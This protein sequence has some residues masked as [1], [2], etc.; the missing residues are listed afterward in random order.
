MITDFFKYTLNNIGK[1]RMRSWLTMLG[2]F[3]GIASVVALIGLGSGLEEAVL[4][5][6][7]GLG[8]DKI[9]V[10]ASGGFGPPGSSRAAELSYDDYDVVKKVN[11][12]DVVTTRLLKSVSFEWDNIAKFPFMA[13]IPMDVDARK[14]VL[15]VFDFKM[16]DGR[17][18]QSDDRGKVNIG[19]DLAY[20]AQYNKPIKAGDSVLINNKRYEVV[21]VFQETGR[22]GQGSV[23]IM[24]DDEMRDLLDVGDFISLIVGKVQNI[25]DIDRMQDTITRRLRKS[26]DVKEGDEDFDVQTAQQILDSFGTIFGTVQAVVVGIAGISL[27][28]GAIGIMNTMYTAVLERRK[29]IGIMKAIG[30]RNS[31]ILVIFILESGFLGLVG[32][33]VGIIFGVAFAELAQFG[34]T[35]AMGSTLIRASFDPVVLLLLL[36]FSFIIGLVSGYLPA[37]QAAAL[38]PV[39]ALRI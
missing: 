8:S 17:M 12:W 10:I 25:D 34:A 4:G 24:N 29:E 14:L 11:G 38:Q 22:A 36:V 33:L 26:R 7:M 6:F 30:A 5:E 13:S 3:I 37:R 23:I 1:R 27:I 39:D 20:D 31:N 32:G 16:E 28:V 9:T 19:Y 2:I 35:V 15:E 18:L 21:G